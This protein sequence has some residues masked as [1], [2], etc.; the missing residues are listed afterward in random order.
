MSSRFFIFI[1]LNW[2]RLAENSPLKAKSLLQN[3]LTMWDQSPKF[4][5]ANADLPIYPDLLPTNNYDNGCNWILIHTLINLDLWMFEKIM[6]KHILVHKNMN[7]SSENILDHC[8][9][10]PE[11]VVTPCHTLIIN[12]SRVSSKFKETLCTFH[13]NCWWKNMKPGCAV[14]GV[15]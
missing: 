7:S 10:R 3:I 5:T 1:T 9:Q 8:A 12:S 11:A 14:G 15:N 2:A 4:S 6:W 13:E